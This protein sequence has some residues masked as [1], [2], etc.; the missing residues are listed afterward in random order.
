M[1]GIHNT[2]EPDRSPLIL[3]VI[4]LGGFV[5]L[6]YPFILKMIADWDQ[7]DNYSHGYFIPFVSAYLIYEMRNGLAGIRLQPANWGLIILVLGL[8]QL[9]VA[10]VGTEFFLQRTSMIVVLFGASLFL[11]GTKFTKNIWFPIA[12]F[13]FMVPLPAIIWNKF[14]FPMQLFAS[15][16]TEKVIQA[17]GIPIF[18]EGN[19]LNLAQTSLEVVDACS[20][21]RSLVT[22]F[23][24][25]SLLAYLSKTSIFKKGILF[26]AA[27][28]IAIFVN[29]VR[30]TFTAGLAHK[31]GEKAAQGFLHDFSGW[32]IFV[33][34][35]V[36]LVGVKTLLETN[37]G[38]P[39]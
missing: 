20:G 19:V 8:G 31:F 35:I 11:A 27:I 34:G 17:I 5:V 3:T 39:D 22:M 26:L 33:L 36:L 6:Y 16:I 4:F 12:Y 37:K 30:L 24:L 14:A 28:P 18:R 29:I 10:K 38:L 21:L 13:I 1:T 2:D 9:L 15:A 23:A 25:S 7:N 32:L